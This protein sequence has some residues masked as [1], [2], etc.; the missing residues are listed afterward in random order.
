MSG[1]A[2]PPSLP[3]TLTLTPLIAINSIL[4]ALVWFMNQA[5]PFVDYKC[6]E[7]MELSYSDSKNSFM[8]VVWKAEQSRWKSFMASHFSLVN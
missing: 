5:K 6:Y 7:R 2:A 1:A 8:G 3:S 4:P